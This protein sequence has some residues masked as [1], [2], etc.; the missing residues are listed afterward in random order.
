[1]EEAKGGVL[2]AQTERGMEQS[3]T[4]THTHTRS[5]VVWALIQLG[6]LRYRGRE[7]YSNKKRALRE[8]NAGKLSCRY[9]A[10]FDKC[11]EGALHSA[12]QFIRM[13]SFMR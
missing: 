7:S 12:L 2:G 4:H 1:M 8:G 6:M 5:A 3:H 13:I 9:I 10:R 11:F